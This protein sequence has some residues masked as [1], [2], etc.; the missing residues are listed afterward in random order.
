VL[1]DADYTVRLAD[2]GY[3]SLVGNI[4]EALNYLQ[5]STARP[6]ALRW[7]A[8]EQVDL[9]DTLNSTTKTN[10]YSFGCVALRDVRPQ[11]Q[12]PSLADILAGFIREATM[13]RG[14]GGLSHRVALGKG[15]H[16][17]PTRVSN[18]ERLTLEFNSR[19]LVRNRGTP[20]G[21][22]DNIHHWTVFEPLPTVP[23]P[24]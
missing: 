9:D 6:G 24:P 3:A 17:R 5:I 12:M 20:C 19:L 13:V 10:I 16:T 4:P 21:G 23:S 22:G 11:T 14:P 15:A 8:P 2:F 18:V 1:L 7:I